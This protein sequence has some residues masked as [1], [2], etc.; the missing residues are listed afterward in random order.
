MFNI[1]LQII[2]DGHL[3]D[4]K[5]HRVDFRN[6][7]IIMTINVGRYPLFAKTNHTLGFSITRVH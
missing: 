1:L 5:G 3:T 4:A 7:V 6:T 2:D